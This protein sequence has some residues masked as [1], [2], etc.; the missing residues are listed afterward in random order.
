MDSTVLGL[1][2]M[3]PICM[4][5]ACVSAVIE[6]KAEQ[7]YSRSVPF[8][9]KWGVGKPRAVLTGGIEWRKSG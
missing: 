8:Y 7:W 3:A 2:G 5:C 1:Y 9:T 4:V 6:A